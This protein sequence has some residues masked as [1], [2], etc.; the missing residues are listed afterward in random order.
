METVVPVDVLR[1]AGVRVTLAG[2]AGGE[3]VV[4]SR[5][6]R[7]H[8]DLPLAEALAG[9]GDFDL[10]VLP[11]GADGAR[12]LAAAPQVRELLR[13]QDEA[14]R[15]V[16]AICAGP[17]ALEAAGVIRGRTFTSHPA[18]REDLEAAGGWVARPV[19]RDGNLITSQGPG[20]VFPFALH[21]VAALRGEEAAARVAAPMLVEVW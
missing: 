10:V 11:G 13:R 1:R 20:T 7:I 5:G 15:L 9:E 2:L 4:C 21:L 19:V 3:A 18:V 6:V 12:A 17:L 14:G 16:A 8:P